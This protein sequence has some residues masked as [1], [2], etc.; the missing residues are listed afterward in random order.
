MNEF[1]QS[2]QTREE[3]LR[4]TTA[5]PQQFYITENTISTHLQGDTPKGQLVNGSVIVNKLKPGNF[6]YAAVPPSNDES[7]QRIVTTIF[8]DNQQS[9]NRV[10]EFTT[11]P[12]GLGD[13]RIGQL[14][15][16]IYDVGNDVLEEDFEVPLLHDGQG[17]PNLI[18]LIV[19]PGSVA[20]A[21]NFTDDELDKA[22]FV[23][24][25]GYNFSGLLK[26]VAK[27]VPVLAQT[28]LDIYHEVTKG[29]QNKTKATLPEGIF[30][31]IGSVLDTAVPFVAALI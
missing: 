20:I 14:A 16:K 9:S 21:P 2:I 30:S 15:L 10:F 13:N 18:P 4:N 24:G 23:K 3:V 31:S 29:S 7:K 27:A 5:V 8:S 17:N 26:G 19:G 1:Q 11:M 28:G 22:G 6:A 12:E 25:A